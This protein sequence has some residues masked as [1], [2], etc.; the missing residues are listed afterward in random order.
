MTDERPTTLLHDGWG[1]PRPLSD[2]ELARANRRMVWEDLARIAVLA[3][4]GGGVV[5]LVLWAV[6]QLAPMP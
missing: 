2:A 6:L 4:L 3:L 1:S 5:L